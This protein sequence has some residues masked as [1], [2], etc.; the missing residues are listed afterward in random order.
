MKNTKAIFLIILG[1]F[2]IA[3]G[4]AFAVESETFTKLAASG[5][6]WGNRSA[7]GQL[8]DAAPSGTSSN[9]PPVSGPTSSPQIQQPPAPGKPSDDAKAEE[10]KPTFKENLNKYLK[11]HMSTM[12]MTAIGAYAGFALLG[13]PIGLIIGALFMYSLNYMGNN[14]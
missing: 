11:E 2:I 14:V 12:A 3:T 13:G 8:V 7:T 10:K 6:P 9:L 1:S 5:D 4:F